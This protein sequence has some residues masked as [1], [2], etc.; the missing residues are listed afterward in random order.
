MQP[1]LR[2]LAQLDNAYVRYDRKP[3]GVSDQI[4]TI[5]TAAPKKKTFSLTSSSESL[6][7]YYPTK[8]TLR[9]LLSAIDNVSSNQPATDSKTDS[10]CAVLSALVQHAVQ[11]AKSLKFA[12]IMG[13]TTSATSNAACL[14]AGFKVR[15]QVDLTTF[16][17]EG[18]CLFAPVCFDAAGVSNDDHMLKLVVM[19]L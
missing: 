6:L 3:A 5:V 19:N 9:L 14:R 1:I 13:E 18:Q 15:A 16:E 7:H 11:M 2:V 17:Y 8:K 4:E 10:R 12:T